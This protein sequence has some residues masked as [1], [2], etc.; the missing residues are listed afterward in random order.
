MARTKLD[1]TLT[2]LTELVGGQ[3]RIQLDT[4]LSAIE[5][6]AIFIVVG[7]GGTYRTGLYVDKETGELVRECS[8]QNGEIHVRRPTCSHFLAV[9]LVMNALGC[10][11]RTS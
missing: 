8:C 9:E 11:R 4:P 10:P 3:T 1:K 2:I 6:G 7:E 5:R